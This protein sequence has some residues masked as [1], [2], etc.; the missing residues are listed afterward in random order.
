M[1]FIPLIAIPVLYFLISLL[2][3]HLQKALPFNICAICLAVS[4][5]WLVL[6]PLFLLG[7][8]E[9]LPLAILMGMSLTGIMYKLEGT[10]KKNK[11]KNFWF[12]RIALVVGGFYLISSLLEQN[13]NLFTLIA[14]FLPIS[15]FLSGFFFQGSQSPTKGIK[16]RL[17]DCC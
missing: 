4:L 7:K 5:T 12:A 16:K 15:I 8:V 3:P 2:K 1:I 17:E 14:I 6:L 13:W 11:L 9:P 10:F